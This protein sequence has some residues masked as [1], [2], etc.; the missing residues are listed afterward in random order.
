ME[1][2][3]PGKLII[4]TADKRRIDLIIMS[5]HGRTGFKRALLG[6]TTEFVVRH[7]DCPVLT[8]R[9][10]QQ[11]V[12]ETSSRKTQVRPKSAR[13]LAVQDQNGM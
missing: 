1:T 7:A 12:T 8:V 13:G 6:S 9:V 5:P 10:Q 11:G 2:G 4:K 3:H